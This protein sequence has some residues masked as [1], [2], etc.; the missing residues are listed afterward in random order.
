MQ[1]GSGVVAFVDF[2]K[3]NSLPF[4]GKVIDIGCGK[5]RNSV[6]LASLG[7]EVY[8]VDYIK[9]ALQAAQE[10]ANR[11]GAVGEIH[12]VQAELDSPWQFADEYFDIAIDCFSSIDIETRAGRETYRNEMLRTLKPNGC[13]MINV[14]SS[15]D[16]WEREAIANNPG[17]EPN[18][19]YWPTG[20]FQKNYDEAELR[21]FYKMFEIAELKKVSKPATKLGRSGTATNFW[22]ILRKPV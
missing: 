2:L 16:E 17:K 22:T 8:A 11:R 13:A 21:E 5:G 6:Y 9:P 18:S 20:K 15:D 19:A 1:P 12:F 10:L 7:F 4:R 14:C 3:R